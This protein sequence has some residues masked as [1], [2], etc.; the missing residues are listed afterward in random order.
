MQIL[1]DAG[2]LIVIEVKYLQTITIQHLFRKGCQLIGVEAYFLEF[3]AG[4]EPAWYRSDFILTEVNLFQV[5]AA[6][7]PFWE[8][9]QLILG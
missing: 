3:G 4:L 7:Q 5:I 9:G 2:D 8:V 6:Y 1:R